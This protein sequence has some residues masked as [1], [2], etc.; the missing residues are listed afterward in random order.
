MGLLFFAMLVGGLSGFV[1]WA[2]CEPMNPGLGNQLA[3]TRWENVFLLVLGALIGGAVGGL[4]GWYQGSRTHLLRGVL[5]GVVVGSIGGLLGMSIGGGLANLVTRG[6]SISSVP[7]GLAIVARTIA[8]VPVGALI[9]A[10]IGA[11]G[12]S[13]RRAAVGALGGGIGG[14][15]SGL[16][17]DLV[18]KTLAPLILTAKGGLPSVNEMGIPTVVAETGGPSRAVFAVLLGASIGLFTA[19]FARL[20]RSAWVRLVLGRNEGKE[21]LVDAPQTFIG[22][23]ERAHIP[24][25]GDMNIAPMHACIQKQGLNYTLV[26]G[27]S[28]IGTYVNGQR[29]AQCPLM[30]GA[31]IHLGPYQLVFSI[32]G[33]AAKRAGEAAYA[34]RA[35]AST[36]NHPPPAQAG[37]HP[38]PQ[39]PMG[40][41]QVVS[42]VAPTQQIAP[43]SYV[44]PSAS[45][46]SGFN[47]VALDGPLAGQ[48]FSIVGAIEIGR[49]GGA[50]PLSF[51]AGVSRRHARVAPGSTGL[52][53]QD[54]GSTNGTFVNGQRATQ[55]TI[56][57]GD[58]VKIGAT[59]F[60]VE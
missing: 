22:R 30:N 39:A 36:S 15:L 16:T 9:G 24:L 25:F 52:E 13:W 7:M 38:Y 55:T 27:G 2:I 44:P 29:I 3:W 6:Q 34:S 8:F 42:A 18:A 48:R 57:P 12:L 31:V 43:P 47:L 59:S 54:L 28:P 37:P 4:N 41:T 20:T 19:L 45:A 58:V 32:R 49:E 14:L 1:G 53:L 5:V 51:D 60:R 33:E 40:A 50:I 56:R 10:V 17:F 21:W 46:T 23:S 11:S 26:D 35:Y